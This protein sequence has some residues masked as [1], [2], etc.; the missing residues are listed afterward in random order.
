MY[1]RA[2]ALIKEALDESLGGVLGSIKKAV[3]GGVR[4][5]AS[6]GRNLVRRNIDDYRRAQ[7]MGSEEPASAPEPAEP[8]SAPAPS[9]PDYS[10]DFDPSKVSPRAHPSDFD[11]DSIRSGSLPDTVKSAYGSSLSAGS[12]YNAGAASARSSSPDVSAA[13]GSSLAASSR[14]NADASNWRAVTGAKGRRARKASG[15]QGA[16]AA[17]ARSRGASKAAAPAT[18]RRGGT[19]RVAAPASSGEAEGPFRRGRAAARASAERAPRR[20]KVAASVNTPVV[21]PVDTPAANDDITSRLQA[22]L[23]ALKTSVDKKIADKTGKPEGQVSTGDVAAETPAA[24][25]VKPTGT[26]GRKGR[27]AAGGETKDVTKAGGRR[28]RKAQVGDALNTMLGTTKTSGGEGEGAPTPAGSGVVVK[29]EPSDTEASAGIK[30][31]GGPPAVNVPEPFRSASGGTAAGASATGAS[32]PAALSTNPADHVERLAK[33]GLVMPADDD[34]SPKAE[35]TRREIASAIDRFNRVDQTASIAD[36]AL[37]AV[38]STKEPESSGDTP[39]EGGTAPQAPSRRKGRAGK[40]SDAEVEADRKKVAD[41]V[42]DNQQQVVGRAG[43]KKRGI[44][45]QA[46]GNAPAAPE[47]SGTPAAGGKAPKGTQGRSGAAERAAAQKA[48]DATRQAEKDRPLSPPP[49]PPVAGSAPASGS[50]A[51]FSVGDVINHTTYGKGTIRGF[52]GNGDN[53]TLH[54]HFDDEPETP[55]KIL[56]RLPSGEKHLTVVGRDAKI[57]R[58]PIVAGAVPVSVEPEAVASRAAANNKK[59]AAQAAKGDTAAAKALSDQDSDKEAI[60]GAV[61]VP[62]P[63]SATSGTGKK[64]GG[65]KR[66]AAIADVDK[67]IAKGVGKDT[68]LDLESGDDFTPD[69]LGAAK[70]VSRKTGKIDTVEPEA[71]SAPD[72]NSNEAPKEL[73]TGIDSGEQESDL[74]WDELVGN[75]GGSAGKKDREGNWI[76]SNDLFGRIAKAD[77]EVQARRA[78]GVDGRNN[79]LTFVKTAREHAQDI[80]RAR[81]AYRSALGQD[82]P[83]HEPDLEYSPVYDD[84]IMDPYTDVEGFNKFT[85]ALAKIGAASGDSEDSEEL[86]H[87]S[88]RK[89]GPKKPAAP[90]EEKPKS[91]SVGRKFKV[92][93]KTYVAL[94]PLK[95]QAAGAKF[96]DGL[97]VKT[98]KDKFK[99]VGDWSP[100]G[101]YSSI[102]GDG[103]ITPIDPISDEKKANKEQAA[104]KKQAEGQAPAAPKTPKATKAKATKPATKKKKAGGK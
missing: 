14:Y 99:R 45:V 97:F 37:K 55:K 91:S 36:A 2:D 27:K 10:S 44:V 58:T 25:T 79:P 65:K 59:L 67:D 1:D 76:S 30:I 49:S 18:A 13:Y 73:E 20:T 15:K 46:T 38:L 70:A 96:N 52:S 7:Q 26:K 8:A 82:E 74:D 3:V 43:T 33:H 87:P 6:R 68:L 102:V 80:Q 62:V 22:S 93:N 17:P 50:E 54:I 42:R 101:D 57:K 61:G 104:Q 92:G 56:S 39:I 94:R 32:V 103:P 66:A 34:E 85:G 86:V 84:D 83:A 98:G 51:E 81:E 78:K 89:K 40:K 16:S 60:A 64:G 88:E 35:K 9:A 63:R 24:P 69:D 23:D 29:A 75:T 11:T 47:K 21:A 5:I 90:K 71:P 28:G 100:T 53:P 48:A 72:D 12:Q 4:G 77:Q 31:S 41:F 19:S 95:N